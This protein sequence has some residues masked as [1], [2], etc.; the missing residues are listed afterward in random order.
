MPDVDDEQEFEHDLGQDSRQDLVEIDEDNPAASVDLQDIQQADQYAEERIDADTELE[1]IPTQTFQ[2]TDAD[3]SLFP[4]QD[5]DEPQTH[6]IFDQDANDLSEEI[7]HRRSHD[8]NPSQFTVAL[9]LWCEEAGISRV[10]YT[11]LLEIL[12]MPE[13]PQKVPSLP[14]SLST[15]KKQ[16]SAILPLLSMRKQSIPLQ[17]AQQSRQK[18]EED[19][20][21]FD[22]VDL[23]KSVAASNIAHTL[24]LGLGEFHDSHQQDELFKSSCWTSSIRTTSGEYAHYPSGQPV[25]PSDFASFRCSQRPPFCT[26]CPSSTTGYFHLGRVLGVG[27]DYRAVAMEPKGQVVIQLQEVLHPQHVASIVPINPPAAQHER[28][29]SWNTVFC[30]TEA[31]LGERINVKLDYAFG[32]DKLA[33]RPATE[34]PPQTMVVRRILDTDADPPQLTPLC[35]SHPI[36]GELEIATFGRDWLQQLDTLATNRR[37]LSLPFLTFIDGFGLYRNTYRTLM[38]MYFILA[39]LP[40]HERARRAN[41]FPFTIG[42]HGSNFSDVVDGVRSL[43]TL[44]RGVE[45]EIPGMGKVMLLAF[46]IAFIGDMPQQQKNSG[47]KTQRAHLGCRFCHVNSEER[48]ALDYDIFLEGRYHHTVM[49]MREDL[50]A[51]PTRAAREAY[52]TQWGIDPDPTSMALT[53]IAPALDIVQSRPGDPAHSEYQGLSNMLH[54]LLLE[55]ILTPSATKEYSAVLQAFPFPPSWPRV[56]GPL[57]HLKSYS[58]SEHARW[59][60]IIPVL[61]RCWLRENHIRSHLLTVLRLNGIDDPVDHVVTQFAAAARSNLVLMSKVVGREDRDNMTLIVHG[62]REQLQQLLASLAQ[63]MAGDRRRSR[64]AS[65]AASSSQVSGPA[66]NEQ[67]KK[68]E[69]YESHMKRPNMHVAVHYPA[70]AEEYGLP[71]NMNVLVGE[72]KHRAFK[73]WIYTTNHRHPEKDLLTKENKRQTLR[74]LLADAFKT[75]EPIATQLI[76]DI[77]C[78]CPQLFSTLLPRSEQMHLDGSLPVDDDED[79]EDV[80]AD[81]G[82]QLPIV[83]GCIRPKYMQSLNLPTRMTEM[84]AHPQFSQAL[85]IAYGDYGMPDIIVFTGSLQWCKRFSF[86]DPLTQRRLSFKMGDFIR[87]SSGDANDILRIDQILVHKYEGQRRLFVKATRVDRNLGDDAVLGTGF[88]HLHVASTGSMHLV[89]LPSIATEH[90]YVVPIEGNQAPELAKVASDATEF[91]WAKYTVSWL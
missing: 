73:K 11:S 31:K 9:G 3:D 39:G 51:L 49:S 64:S 75:T 26:A 80:L 76:K 86:Y 27:R 13:L 36:R 18:T 62:Y 7:P 41:V 44:D 32:N 69:A 89:G 71:V 37:T 1:N 59:S 90:L 34:Y 14:K 29:L 83:T 43:A 85:S 47:M 45:V 88:C 35:L 21:F 33:T 22:P 56:Q 81:D 79:E 53:S 60:I 82:H 4:P 72:D 17:H 63:A 58:L 66:R 61:L 28:I 19:L 25:F 91:L 65:A 67:S 77:Y 78:E 52:G 23:F 48:G 2:D 6:S 46:P 68:A 70:L 55:A 12:R 50:D 38:G 24:H 8:P 40:F 20:I 5:E 30:C 42:P 16:T 54:S 10:Q 57:H 15:L 87:R 84:S 74:L